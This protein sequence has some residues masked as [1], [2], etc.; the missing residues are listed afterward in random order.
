MRERL[1]KMTN[2][3]ENLKADWLVA[4]PEDR[5]PGGFPPA[6]SKVGAGILKLALLSGDCFK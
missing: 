6:P 2:V 1:K 4:R 5:K 3:I